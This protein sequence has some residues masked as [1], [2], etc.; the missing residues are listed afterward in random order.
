L[1]FGGESGLPKV[2]PYILDDVVAALDRVAHYDWRG[3]LHARLDQLQA[4]APLGGLEKAGWALAYTD[5][6]PPWL[7]SVEE[8]AKNTDLRFSIG[9]TV[10]EDGTIL[11]VI[12]DLPAA[13]A[14]MV[15]GTKLVAVNGRKWSRKVL[16]EAIRETKTRGRPLELLVE[17]AEFYKTCKL[18]YSGGERYARLKRVEGTADVLGDIIASK[19]TPGRSH[20]R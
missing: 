10:K 8:A 20:G 12:P 11:D 9:I 13:R 1:F 7:K 4:H 14:G 17:N 16:R 2:M 3:F 19:A 6:I 15:P 18:E 5:S